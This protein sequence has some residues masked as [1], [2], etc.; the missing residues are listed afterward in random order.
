MERLHAMQQEFLEQQLE[1]TVTG[2]EGHLASGQHSLATRQRGLASIRRLTVVVEPEIERQLEHRLIELGATG[3]TA[4]ACHGMGRHDLNDASEVPAPRVR[5]EVIAPPR[6][7]DRM[8]DYLSQE[9]MP[10]HFITAC[11]ETVDV[12]RLDSFLTSEN[13]PR[14]GVSH[15]PDSI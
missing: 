6:V 2:M 11:A 1:L 4:I 5:I 7:V 3:Y 10:K 13:S 14:L 15:K 8:L 9:I 12:L